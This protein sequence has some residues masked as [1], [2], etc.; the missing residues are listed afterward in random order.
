MQM[1]GPLLVG[2]WAALLRVAKFLTMLDFHVGV[3]S[4]PRPG[5]NRPCWEHPGR[6][7]L[8]ER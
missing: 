8:N 4:F 2:G 7:R 5:D 6:S 1:G 3:D